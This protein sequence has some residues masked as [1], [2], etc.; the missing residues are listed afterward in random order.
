[1]A[2]IWLGL[3]VEAD[4]YTEMAGPGILLIGVTAAVAYWTAKSFPTLRFKLRSLLIAGGV[5]P[6]AVSLVWFMYANEIL[7]PTFG[8]LRIVIPMAVAT[9]ILVS[10]LD[11][12]VEY[13][14]RQR[15]P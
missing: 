9:F 11:E 1:M 13:V 2:P 14:G 10:W 6:P 15:S 5:F 4:N 7:P 12:L 3:I 8:S